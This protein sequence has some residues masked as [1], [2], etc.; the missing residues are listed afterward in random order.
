MSAQ[1]FS[2]L[3][4]NYIELLKDDEYYDITIEV[5][6]DP[7][8]PINRNNNTN[9]LVHIRLPNIS[10]EIFQIILE[11]IYGGILPLNMNDTSDFLKVLVAADNLHLEDLVDYLQKY[12][13]ENKFFSLSSKEFLQ[14]V[15]PY[16]KLLNNQL[17]E[18]IVNSHMNPDIEP[19]N[20][21]SPPRNIKIEK[22]IDSKI[23]N[24]DIVSIFSKWI[25]KTVIINNS[26]YDHLREL[27]L[28]YKFKL[29]LRGSRDGF[30]P[31]KFH[32]LCDGKDN[33]V[34]FIKVKGSEEILGGYNPLEWETT[35]KWCKTNDSFIFSFKGK[36]VKNAIL[37]NVIDANS[38]LD[39]SS[40]CGPTF[41]CDLNICNE[42]DEHDE[43]IAFDATY[44]KKVFYERNIRDTEEAFPIE[45]YEV[46]QIIRK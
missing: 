33:T 14:K 34:T 28:P 11:Y 20:N 7:N 1:F 32:E 41:G 30:T 44:C 12:L 22:I 46:F 16:K 6:E 2:K 17:Y 40:T 29:L 35:G 15:R 26:K 10:S 9:D 37:S 8:I 5:G 31:K 18:D 39:F 13:V 25:D 19:A 21:I 24:L 43:Y 38:A 42:Y 23:V 4:Q 36:N 45:D 3:S 27:Y